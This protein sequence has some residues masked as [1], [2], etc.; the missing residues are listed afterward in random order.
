[1]A[2]DIIDNRNAKL[3]DHFNGILGTA[4]AAKMAVVPRII[5]SEALV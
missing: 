5:C 3:V 1:M 4:E 2:H